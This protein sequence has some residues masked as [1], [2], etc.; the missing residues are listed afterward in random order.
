MAWWVWALL[1]WLVLSTVVA[2]WLGAVAAAARR[3]EH[4]RRP[5]GEGTGTRP[6]GS[7]WEIAG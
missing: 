5:A 1:G 3:Q 6:Q 7:E 2:F 4:A